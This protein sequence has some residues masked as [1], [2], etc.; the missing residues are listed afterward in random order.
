MIH[1]HI[2]LGDSGTPVSEGNPRWDLG[3][4]L[5]DVEMREGRPR[6]LLGGAVPIVNEPLEVESGLGSLLG[7]D[8]FGLNPFIFGPINSHKFSVE[9]G[10]PIDMGFRMKCLRRVEAV[11]L[12]VPCMLVGMLYLGLNACLITQIIPTE[13][14]L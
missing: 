10:G 7:S 3:R 12:C 6:L 4:S 2:G 11:S 1:E 9:A 8:P 13:L 14:V 5:A